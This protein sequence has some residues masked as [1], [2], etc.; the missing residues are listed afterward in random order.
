VTATALH[1]LTLREV[2]DPDRC[3]RGVSGRRDARLPGADRSDRSAAVVVHHGGRRLR[4]PG[5]RGGREGDSGGLPPRPAAGRADRDQG[6]HRHRGDP[7]H[8]RRAA[9]ARSRSTS[10]TRPSCTGC[11]APARSS[12]ASSTSTSTPTASPPTT[13]ITGGRTIVE[14]RAFARRLER[15]FG[16]CCR[17]PVVLGALGTDTGC[18]VAAAGLLQRDRR[19][20]PEYRRISNHGVGV[21]AWTLDT[22]GPMCRTVE[23]CAIM[24]GAIAGH[25]PTIRRVPRRRCPTTARRSSAASRVCASRCWLTSRSAGCRRVSSVRQRRGRRARARRR[26]RARGAGAGPRAEHLRSPHRRYRRAG[27]PTTRSGCAGSR[28]TTARTC[29]RCSRPASST[30]PPTTSRRS[31]IA[32]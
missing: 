15:R 17:C 7:H 6:P 18:S 25:D 29:G 30:W 32:P 24:F 9:G 13:R 21:L 1:E 26:G 14:P 10:A 27:P 3:R 16:S 22:V 2:G 5:R 31:A 12:S 19:D 11:G 20:P 28:R 23:D 4:P 8:G